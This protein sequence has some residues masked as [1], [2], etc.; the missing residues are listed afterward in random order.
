[1]QA[2]IVTGM[3]LNR[4]NFSSVASEKFSPPGMAYVG[5]R[6]GIEVGVDVRV[7]VGR[8]KN[9]QVTGN[10]SIACG[11]FTARAVGN[12]RLRKQLPS[13]SPVPGFFVMILG[14]HST[15]LQTGVYS[16]N[17]WCVVTPQTTLVTIACHKTIIVQCHKNACPQTHRC[18][19]NHDAIYDHRTYDRSRQT[20]QH[21]ATVALISR[22]ARRQSGSLY[23]TCVHFCGG[24]QVL[25]G[26]ILLS[27]MQQQNRKNIYIHF[28]N[29][30]IIIVRRI[31]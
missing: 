24:T 16:G 27:R 14:G 18:R 3:M 2:V 6:V 30:V 19:R 1:M 26:K 7:G 28:S 13:D 10:R 23:H 8:R 11:S 22:R 4:T 31:K 21:D 25:W 20:L 9:N 12:R 15:G 17:R 5:V 29:Y